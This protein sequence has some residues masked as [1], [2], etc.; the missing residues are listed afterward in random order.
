M[1]VVARPSAIDAATSAQSKRLFD[2]RGDE[3]AP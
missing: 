3:I 1:G 2:W